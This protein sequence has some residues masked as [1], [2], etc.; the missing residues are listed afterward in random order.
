MSNGMSVGDDQQLFERTLAPMGLPTDAFERIASGEYASLA[1]RGM[2]YGWKAARRL[3]VQPGFA[4][5]QA[6]ECTQAMLEAAMKAAVASGLV[7][8]YVD[9]ETYLRHWNGMQSCI[10]AALSAGAQSGTPAANAADV[11]G[12]MAALIA[13]LSYSL[14]RAAP[15]HEAPAQATAY[16]KK[17][18]LLG[19]PLRASHCQETMNEAAVVSAD[20]VN[21]AKRWRFRKQF[22]SSG[23]A[24]MFTASGCQLRRAGNLVS[25]GDS[26]EQAIDAA[27]TAQATS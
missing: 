8:K 27:M 22:L 9:T 7:P 26:E 15:G 25:T 21:D 11:V 1:T 10:E 16:L 23:G 24:I 3:L 12:D 5:V 18:N 13:R 20:D 19:S 14:K 2:W 4:Q 6:S 17:H